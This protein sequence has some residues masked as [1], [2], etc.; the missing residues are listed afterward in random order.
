MGFD[1]TFFDNSLAESIKPGGKI[2]APVFK[3][4]QSTQEWE[5][6][7][8]LI[9]EIASMIDGYK[10]FDEFGEIIEVESSVA[11]ELWLSTFIAA[12]SDDRVYVLPYGN[13]SLRFLNRMAPGELAFYQNRAMERLSILLGKDLLPSTLSLK[14]G[15]DYSGE[16]S[17]IYTD[18]RKRMRAL[19]ELAPVEA[20][21]RERLR[22][23]QILTPTK[24]GRDFMLKDFTKGARAAE[25]NVRIIVGNYTITSER[26]DL[27]ITFIND[28]D[29]E[30]TFD[31]VATLSN[32]KMSLGEIPRVTIPARSQ[33]QLELPIFAITSGETIIN[34]QKYT[35]SGNPVGLPAEIPIRLAVI[36]PL[37]TWF[38]IAMAVILFLAAIIQSIRRVK[39]RGNAQ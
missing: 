23:A 39:R 4:S 14:K 25:K 6:D 9:E 33:I 20:V 16:T 7:V 30:V 27:P 31:L 12:V 5:V 2:G 8:A 19:Y 11:A 32:A 28:F 24:Y 10:Y 34:L 1:G 29:L 18:L 13:P 36:S 26:Y 3:R 22:I 15:K 21:E 38:T 17:A 37:T 35:L